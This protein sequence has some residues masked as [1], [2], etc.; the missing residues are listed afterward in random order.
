MRR[1]APGWWTHSPL[2][3]VGCGTGL[4]R[5]AN[6]PARRSPA[7]ACRETQDG[8]LVGDDGGGGNGWPEYGTAAGCGSL[9]SLESTGS[10]VH[11]AQG[12]GLPTAAGRGR[13]H[14]A[15][16]RADTDSNFHGQFGYRSAAHAS[17]RF[18]G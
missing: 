17:G 4:P 13:S 15:R 5:D 10:L 11:S 14:T 8:S 3:E 6:V 16:A 7:R 18:G 9:T 1:S 2:G 12:R